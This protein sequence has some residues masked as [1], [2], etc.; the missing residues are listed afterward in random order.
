M[1]QHV[2]T[3]FIHTHPTAGGLGILPLTDISLTS[4]TTHLI[5]MLTS[6]DS[7]TRTIARADVWQHIQHSHHTRNLEQHTTTI[8][9]L[10]STPTPDPSRIEHTPWRL[11]PTNLKLLDITLAPDYSPLKA[12]T[13]TPL[14]L[15]QVSRHLRQQFY[16]QHLSRLRTCISQRRSFNHP[17]TM[18]QST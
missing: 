13:T 2:T 18:A 10:N 1:G 5:Q 4:R 11:L 15:Y 16:I 9:Y 14:T 6:P 17:H 12:I 7:S 3:A 8:N